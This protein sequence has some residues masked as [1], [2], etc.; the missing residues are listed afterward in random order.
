ML[1]DPDQRVVHV[2]RLLRLDG[3][4]DIKERDDAAYCALP[5]TGAPVEMR[6]V[7][8]GDHDAIKACM[9][10]AGLEIYDP[11]DSGTNP[12][13][14]I[15]GL[16]QEVYDL[17]T[18]QLVTPRFFEFTS[19]FP[20]TGAG[21]EEQKALMFVKMPVIAN[22]AGIYTSRMANGARRVILI[23]YE[24]VQAQSAEIT[25]V[26]RTLMQFEPG[27]GT[28]SVHGNTLLGFAGMDAPLCL[29]GLIAA[30]FPSLTYNFEKYTT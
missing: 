29:P 3:I 26:F 16:P 4:R 17:D 6:D 20:S 28:C 18:L 10:S 23:E 15:R 7:I 14:S 30:G 22:R 25:D 11:K 5:L 19:L 8:N 2:R 27:I 13:I 24:D 12:Q 21:I 9:R 1:L